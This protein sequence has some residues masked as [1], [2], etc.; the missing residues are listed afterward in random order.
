SDLPLGMQPPSALHISPARQPLEHSGA[1]WPMGRHVEPA[2]HCA[3]VWQAAPW[4]LQLH[5]ATAA[6]NATN[7]NARKGPDARM[8]LECRTFSSTEP[9]CG[10]GCSGVVMSEGGAIGRG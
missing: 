4:P 2:P 6:Q 7:R 8:A 5:A 1:Q 9:N 10:S 3:L